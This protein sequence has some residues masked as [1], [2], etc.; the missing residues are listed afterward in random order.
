MQHPPSGP[1]NRLYQSYQTNFEKEDT[2]IWH[3]AHPPVLKFW[4]DGKPLLDRSCKFKRVEHMH[5]FI[6]SFLFLFLILCYDNN[7]S[8]I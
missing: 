2:S 8:T 4:V 5:T 1:S 3:D 7:S 6:F